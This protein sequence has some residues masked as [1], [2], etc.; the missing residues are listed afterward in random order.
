MLVKIWQRFH[1]TDG[2]RVEDGQRSAR[3]RRVDDDGAATMEMA[4]SG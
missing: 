3:E 4:D 1:V 2:I